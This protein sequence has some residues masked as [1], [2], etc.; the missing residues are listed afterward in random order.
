MN[1][2]DN[3]LYDLLSRLL[4]FGSALGL[5]V[6]LVGLGMLM[7]GVPT[8]RDPFG[9]PVE[10]VN[11]WHRVDPLNFVELGMLIL[12]LTPVVGI[13]VLAIG[14]L[15][16]G[17]PRFFLVSVLLLLLIATSLILSVG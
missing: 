7:L 5:S 17:R 3:R 1:H 11:A 12:M 8:S 13:L 10:M 2:L 16:L 15:W 14:F 6:A 9:D 4:L